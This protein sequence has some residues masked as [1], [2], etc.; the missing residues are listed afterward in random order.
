MIP[1]Y[2]HKIK[3]NIVKNYLGS[4]LIVALINYSN[5][6]ITDAPSAQELEARRNFT[7]QQLFNFEIGVSNLNGY[8]RAIVDNTNINP[9]QVNSTLTEASINVSFTAQGGPF[10]PF[11]HIV[12]V[13]GANLNNADPTINGNNRGDTNGTV[14]FVEPVQNTLNPGSAITLGEGT[15]FNYDFKLISAAETL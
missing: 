9:I 2:T 14:I 6:G 3:E 7:T 15:T 4:N 11:T 1:T 10:E 12:I 8:A 13:R 5:L